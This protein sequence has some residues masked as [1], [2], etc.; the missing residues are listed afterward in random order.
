ME[1]RT[2]KR[3]GKPILVCLADDVFYKGKAG[4]QTGSSTEQ[5]EKARLQRRHY[6]ALQKGSGLYYMFRRA[7]D[8]TAPVGGF[9]R[10]FLDNSAADKVKVLY[11]GAETGTS[12]DLRG[13]LARI[14]KAVSSHHGRREIAITGLFNATASEI[15]EAVNRVQPSIV[16]LAGKQDGG[17]IKLHNSRRQLVPHAADQLASALARTTSKSLKLVILDTC[18]SMGQAKLLTKLGIGHA[19]GIYDGIADDVATEFYATLYSQLASGGDLATACEVARDIVIASVAADPAARRAL[20]DVLEMTFN[21]DIHIPKVCSSR[22]LDAAHEF[23][24]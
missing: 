12:L 10:R 4:A 3:F 1:Y 15:V 16:H 8:L 9:L 18:D 17:T 24:T 13:E 22:G 21:P 11:V 20:E 6:E 5:T 19:I 7:S 14:K 2:A 23:F